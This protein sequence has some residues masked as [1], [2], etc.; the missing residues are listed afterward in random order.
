MAERAVR[1]AIALVACAAMIACASSPPIPT[2][3]DQPAANSPASSGAVALPGTS[4]GSG[5]TPT[6]ATAAPQASGDVDTGWI[7]PPDV[8][9]AAPDPLNLTVTPATASSTTVEVG[10]SGGQFSATGPDGSAYTLTIPAG[11]LPV[12]VGIT[13]TPIADVTGFPFDSAPEHR[14]GVSLTPSGLEFVTPATLTIAPASGLPDAGV[15]TLGFHGNGFD[16][17]ALLA[18]Q[19]PDSLTLQI[20]H[21]SGYVAAWPI[22][23]ADWRVLARQRL[24]FKETVLQHQMAAWLGYKQ[25]LIVAGA[26]PDS[27]ATDVDFAR[28][29]LPEYVREVLEPRINAA[30]NG[31]R[32]GQEAVAYWISYW[33]QAQL[34]GVAGDADTPGD[35][36][37]YPVINGKTYTSVQEYP[38]GL[39]STVVESCLAEDYQHCLANGD[40]FVFYR[41]LFALERE[42]QLLGQQM[43]SG[44]IDVAVGYMQRCG[45]WNLDIVTQFDQGSPRNGSL[46]C[47]AAAGQTTRTMELKWTAGSGAG[48]E[49]IADAK[50]E[51]EGDLHLDRIAFKGNSFCSVTSTQ[52]TQTRKAEAALRSLEFEYP[53]DP[54]TPDWAA[55][56]YPVSLAIAVNLGEA[57]TVYTV[58]CKGV[59]RAFDIP[60]PYDHE[61]VDVGMEASGGTSINRIDPDRFP[62]LFDKGWEYPSLSPFRAH[63]VRDTSYDNGVSATTIHVDMTLTHS[64]Q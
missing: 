44:W 35:P 2:V 26:D 32:E 42:M 40:F 22:K 8:F 50:I 7:F 52:P 21:F 9:T 37:F 12:A 41:R 28:R 57:N 51:G 6:G 20:E 10:A 56:G 25:S 38:V 13:M 49:R 5:A 15:A 59:P 24:E 19:T 60:F 17:G 54:G 39:L 46:A 43:E 1:G 45:H 18:D 55:S 3:S 31:C 16:A 36:D 58:K 47:C 33:R 61:F 14:I 4:P 30:A 29:Q 53:D 63:V 23:E 64:A 34:L 48:L 11:A 27:F 62:L